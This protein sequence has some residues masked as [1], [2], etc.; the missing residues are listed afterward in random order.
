MAAV[1]SIV[2]ALGALTTLSIIAT[3]KVY[4][5]EHRGRPSKYLRE[6]SM[7]PEDQSTKLLDTRALQVRKRLRR[8]LCISWGAWMLPPVSLLII[9]ALRSDVALI[10]A[11]MVTVFPFASLAATS[12]VSFKQA[13]IFKF[14]RAHARLLNV[15]PFAKIAKTSLISFACG[16]VVGVPFALGQWNDLTGY[17][18][19]ACLTVIALLVFLITRS[20]INGSLRSDGKSLTI[21]HLLYRKKVSL[22]QTV[23]VDIVGRSGGLAYSEIVL[24][25][26]KGNTERIP[27]CRFLFV[28][29]DIASSNTRIGEVVLRLNLVVEYQGVPQS[30]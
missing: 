7:E 15:Y 29:P 4:L 19:D 23:I 5:K 22:D 21:S 26:E 6:N 24:K 30:D 8:V 3:V 17:G 16:L 11:A 9:G 18:L 1:V 14:N 20:Q 28:G 27:G 2:A 25:L 12:H 10:G 13:F